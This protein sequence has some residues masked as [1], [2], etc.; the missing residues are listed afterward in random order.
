MIFSV[1]DVGIPGSVVPIIFG[2][3]VPVILAEDFVC[4]F[5][6]HKEVVLTAGVL[7]IY[8]IKYYQENA[9]IYA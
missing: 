8:T 3:V 5:E 4:S 2:P 7:G 9:L 1:F 6:V